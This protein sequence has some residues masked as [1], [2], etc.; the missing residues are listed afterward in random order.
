MSN[1]SEYEQEELKR[2]A[3]WLRNERAKA[4]APVKPQE[5]P[6]FFGKRLGK[7]KV[8]FGSKE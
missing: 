1:W 8:L 5:K 2:Q 4:K 6:Q 7:L 3:E